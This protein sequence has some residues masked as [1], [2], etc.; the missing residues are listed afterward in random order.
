MRNPAMSTP[1]K[2]EGRAFRSGMSKKAAASAPVQAPVPGRG[3]AT[4][5]MSPRYLY[6]VT[7]RPFRWALASSRST[8][9]SSLGR[10]RRIH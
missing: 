9:W 7:F 2:M 3:T 4:K 8:R 5:S 6:F 10:R 1:A